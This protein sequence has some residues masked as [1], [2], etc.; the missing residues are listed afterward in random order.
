MLAGGPRVGCNGG[1]GARRATMRTRKLGRTDIEVPVVTF[2]AWA[3]GGWAWGGKDDENALAAMEAAREVGMTAIDT[4]PVYGFGHSERLVGRA[5]AAGG[6]WLVFTKV[7]LRWDSEEGQLAFE[8]RGADG[9]P[10][11]IFFDSRPE[12][13]RYELEQSLERLGVERIDLFQVHW[14]DPTTPV[15]DTMGALAELHAAGRIRA[16]GVSNYSVEGMAE[17]QRALGDVP[18]AS[19]QPRYSLIYRDIETDVLPYAREHEIGL[20]VYS[21]LEQGLLTG[22]V[23]AEREFPPDDGRHKRP[24]FRPENRARVNALLD[25]V[26]API[27]AAHDATL[28]QVALAWLIAQ[29]G[30]T[31]VI[32]GA[33][34]RQQVLENAAAAELELEPGQLAA[35]DHAFAALELDLSPVE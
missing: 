3:I 30:V 24:T 7:G 33:R 27:A 6:D 23:R 32:A 31:S 12:S 26:V 34:N 28:A 9:K 21:P 25:E 35:I 20:L 5:V 15:A 10:W 11:R 1:A 13:I 22:K 18:L 2:G 4:A 17:A 29:P 16:I 19:D 14:P 8:G